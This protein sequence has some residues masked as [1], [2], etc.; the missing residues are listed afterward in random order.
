MK[1]KLIKLLLP[2]VVA[3][4]S[5]VLGY[6][7]LGG[8]D[9]CKVLCWYSVL[10]L[11]SFVGMPFALLIFK[12]FY[13]GGYIFSKVIGIM[14]AGF[15]MWFLSSC[16]ILKFNIFNCY[17][18]LLIILFISLII[19]MISR[20]KR[21]YCFIQIKEKLS[22][23]IIIECSFLVLFLFISYIKGFNPSIT[24]TTEQFMDYGYMSIMD[25]TDYMPPI[26]MWFSGKYMNYYYFGQYISTFLTKLSGVGVNYGYNLM[27][28]TLFCV[29]FFSGFS[30]CF[31]LSHKNVNEKH[32]WSYIGAFIGG[33]AITIA[34][35]MHYVLYGIILPILNKYFK[36]PIEHTYFFPD[37]TR[38]IGYMPSTNDKTIHEFPSYSFTI[39][40][41]HAHV[42]NIIFVL[43]L[44]GILLAFLFRRREIYQDK[45]QRIFKFKNIINPI[46]II[47][48]MLIG[49]F[50]MT[51]YWDYPIYFV[52]TVAIFLFS[53]IHTFEKIS[54]AIKITLLQS[55]V[56]ILVANIVSLPFTLN[57]VKMASQIKFVTTRTSI[58][59]LLVLWGLPVG[60]TVYYIYVVIKNYNLKGQKRKLTKLLESINLSDLFIIVIG[61]CAVGLVFVPEVVYVKDIYE[62]TYSRANTMFKV[63][64]QAYLLFGLCFGYILVKL[65]SSKNKKNRRKGII[66]LT[67]FIFTLGYSCVCLRSWFGNIKK[68]Q[69]YKTLDG[70]Y[71][72]TTKQFP[73]KDDYNI[74]K[75]L[76][77][78][79]NK[80]DIILESY[81]DSYT[82]SS[83]ISVFTGL[84]TPLGWT[85]HE[86]LWRSINSSTI[87]PEVVSE[88][89]TDIDLIYSSTDETELKKLIKKYNISYIIISYCEREKY[90]DSK[91]T[92]LG[93]EETLM[94]IGKVVYQ[95]NDDK[96]LLASYI[97]KV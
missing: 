58:W 35:N 19:I 20:N 41:L 8:Y 26:D 63:T 93:N 55:I 60:M 5:L 32:I 68:V 7:L 16:H 12:K 13:A 33:L 9:F 15:L 61:L 64:Y 57:F 22:R 11:L 48:G 66:F 3:S 82:Y 92:R 44:V 62:G 70:L 43:T 71:N 59:Q 21:Q 81:G 96:S 74:I 31:N 23:I 79:A 1:Y 42:L 83:R 34:G 25:K 67:L 51:N 24:N 90:G 53:N 88:R 36:I 50:K 40:D 80:N 17:L 85:T 72:Y 65:L 84:A 49:I 87:F 38:Y 29:T 47:I 6:I 78:N 94:N 89:M 91:T 27:L 69:D 39:G 18:C 56:I 14:L 28:I 95:T 37:S 75:W 4:I 77:N 30:I 52:V 10:L 86:H 73:S 76:N 54:D 2:I 45:I 97:I 46:T